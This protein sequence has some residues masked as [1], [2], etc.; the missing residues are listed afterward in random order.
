MMIFEIIR[1]PFWLNSLFKFFCFDDLLVS[2][3]NLYL[4]MSVFLGLLFSV[5]LHHF[6]RTYPRT[7]SFFCYPFLILMD[8]LRIW[9]YYYIVITKELK[10]FTWCDYIQQIL[11]LSTM[12]KKN[13]GFDKILNFYTF[14]LTGRNFEVIMLKKEVINDTIIQFLKT[15]NPNQKI[16]NL[17]MFYSMLK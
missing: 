14:C 17:K 11:S 13:L 8:L 16:L 6:R 2:F 3:Y 12:L 4:T 7:L 1:F 9:N 5:A 15:F 10:L